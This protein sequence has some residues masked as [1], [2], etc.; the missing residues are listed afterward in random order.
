M[1]RS[2]VLKSA[3]GLVVLIA[4]VS[5]SATTALAQV[6][7]PSQVSIQG[8]GY[9]RQARMIRFRRTRQLTPEGF[10]WAIPINLAGGSEPKATM[11]T[12]GTRRERP[13]LRG[14]RR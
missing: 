2:T 5:A 11:D 12:R 6:E 7:Q 4:A 1:E 8:T 14:Q 9:L 10:S 13:L 3:L